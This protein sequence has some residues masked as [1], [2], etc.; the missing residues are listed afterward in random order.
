MTKSKFNEQKTPTHFSILLLPFCLIS[1]WLIE[2]HFIF[3]QEYWG[4]YD[5]WVHGM[6][7][8]LIALPLFQ[9][10]EIKS[11]IIV[12]LIASLLDLDHFIVNFSFSLT[13]AISLTMRPITHSLLFA[14]LMSAAF[15]FITKNKKWT[16]LIF[17]AIASHVVRD[18]YSGITPIFFP[19]KIYESPYWSYLLV[20]VLF[21]LISYF[22]KWEKNFEVY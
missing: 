13:K 7:A 12:F 14:I 10:F 5:N 4:L 3:K 17:V 18:A 21:L 2:H 6:I 22:P 11:F 1:D 9:K 19:I 16:W 20:E 8:V 15:F